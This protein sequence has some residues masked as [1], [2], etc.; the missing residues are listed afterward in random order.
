MSAVYICSL[1]QEVVLI[2]LSFLSLMVAVYIC[3]LLQEVILIL[4][5]FPS[6]MV[7]VYMFSFIGNGS[8]IVIIFKMSAIF[9]MAAKTRH[10]NGG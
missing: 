7:S 4:L 5:S 10:K 6:L 8:H 3:S 9:K 1:L 2:L